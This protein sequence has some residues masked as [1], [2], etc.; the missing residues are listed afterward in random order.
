MTESE[1]AAR[2]APMKGFDPAY[3]DIVDYIV[4]ITHRIW[5]EGDM[6]YIYETYATNCTV[7]TGYGL[8][9]GVENVVGGSVAFLAGFPD[10]RLYAEDVIWAGDDETGFHTSH[11][12]FNTATNTGYS[13]WGPPTGKK[14][15]FLAV[16]NC[17]VR[18]NRI[19]EEWLVR[20]TAALVRQ[21][22]FKVLEV[23]AN[24]PV[25]RPQTFGETDR[26]QGQRPPAPFTP[27]PGMPP[28]E[29]FVR[30]WF[31]DVF[32]LRHF[33]KVAAHH[34]PDAAMFVP[35]HSEVRG[36]GNI[37][38]Y[39]LS[40]TAMFP[41]LHMGVE[42]V[43][44]LENDAKTRVAVRWRLSGTHLHYGPY[45]PPTA[46]PVQALGV[47]HVHLEGETITKHYFVFDELALTAQLVG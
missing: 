44:W 5:E 28:V 43:F 2:Q 36:V 17:F 22:G 34:A 29:A 6:G 12:I 42:H 39:L 20:D 37:R 14:T 1:N 27:P 8:A 41:D 35:N 10:R 11:L 21:L 31:H 47:S 4:G 24:T 25:S 23:A 26:L 46:R 30:G 13:P 32:N 45:G 16:A 19:V 3:K 15:Q 40:L 9:Y 7:H 38:A 33:S 18:E